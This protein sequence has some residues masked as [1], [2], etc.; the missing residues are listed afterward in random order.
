MQVVY[1]AG[2]KLINMLVYVL[3]L[4]AHHETCMYNYTSSRVGKI[5]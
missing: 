3:L 5:Y 1:T 4:R 2:N